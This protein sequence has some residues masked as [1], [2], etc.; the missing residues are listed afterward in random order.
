MIKKALYFFIIFL[1]FVG[2]SFCSDNLVDIIKLINNGRNDE[3]INLLESNGEQNDILLA[4]AY[5][6]KKDFKTAKIY[7]LQYW[8]QNENDILANYLL[9]LI[10]E[11]LKDFRAALMYWNIVIKNVKD[12]SIKNLAKKHIEVLKK[13]TQ[14]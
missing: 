9:A 8:L 14:E 6:G 13:L 7:A 2:V 1:I 10:N 11:E 5:I 12:S 4:I 3:A